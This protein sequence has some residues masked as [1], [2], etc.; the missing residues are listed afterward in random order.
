MRNTVKAKKVSLRKQKPAP[1]YS[2]KQ[3]QGQRSKLQELR[4]THLKH[5]NDKTVI[6]DGSDAAGNN[7]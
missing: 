2:H 4:E 6:I 3:L 5:S 1:K 7:I